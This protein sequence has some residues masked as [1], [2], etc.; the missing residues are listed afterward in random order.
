VA[1][2]AG[3]AFDPSAIIVAPGA[4]VTWTWANTT[5]HNVTF[6]NASITSSSTQAGGTYSTAMPSAA[7]TYSY[8]CTLHAGMSGTVQVQ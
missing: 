4:T 7:G 5:Q 1:L 8:S 3:L 6:A 2:T